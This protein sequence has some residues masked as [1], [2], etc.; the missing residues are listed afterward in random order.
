MS[1]PLVIPTPEG[2]YIPKANAY[3]DPTKKVDTALITH[4]H[5]DHCRRG[6]GTYISTPITAG[7]IQRRYRIDHVTSKEFSQTFVIGDIQCSFYPAGHIPGS[8]QVRIDDGTQVC[9][10]TGDFKR[11][12]D[13]ITNDFEVVPCDHLI[14]ECT[15]GLPYYHW[16]S[17]ATL[18]E[19]FRQWW[20]VNQQLGLVSLTLGYA[21]GKA[22]RLMSMLSD[23]L[24]PIYVHP[25]VAQMNDAMLEVGV[26]LPQYSEW[27]GLQNQELP[28]DAL[29]IAPSSA[30]RAP[31]IQTLGDYSVST[32]SGW[33][34]PPRRYHSSTS[35]AYPMVIS[36]HAD[37]SELIQ[38]VRDTNATKVS[39]MHGFTRP[40]GSQLE[41]LGY[42][43]DI[44]HHV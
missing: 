10:V 26:T 28:K 44:I 16:P 9:V 21:L 32:A 2:L 42:N 7:I 37:W 40:F 41:S 27:D 38:T 25:T 6:H 15:F 18:E 11:A 39:L 12:T 20:Q 3:I 13:R 8:A 29:V 30:L 36:D 17:V 19:E 34:Q 35:H 24:G 5:S 43:V 31:W 22:Q 14:M 33:N 23:P 1:I 4:G